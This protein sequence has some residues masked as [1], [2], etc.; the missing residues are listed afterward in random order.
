M[1]SNSRGFTLVEVMVGMAVF[2]I[3]MLG[4]TAL[5]LSSTRSGAFSANLSEATAL[6]VAKIEELNRLSYNDTG[7]CPN[8]AN[9]N[10]GGSGVPHVIHGSLKDRDLDG[11]TTTADGPALDHVD[12]AA[13]HWLANQGRN[14]AFTIFWNVAVNVP[15][16]T[17][18]KTINVIVR[19]RARNELRS[20]NVKTIRA[21]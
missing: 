13:D 10:C 16:L 11:T 12:D 19:W 17:D 9:H 20:I 3:G 15:P 2:M 18:S 7:G 14:Q 6:A 8:D 4:I 1:R 5:Q 21:Q